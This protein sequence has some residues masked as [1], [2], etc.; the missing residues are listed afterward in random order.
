MKLRIISFA[1]I[2]AGA[3]QL[4][5]KAVAG[6]PELGAL[7]QFS[8]N[9]TGGGAVSGSIYDGAIHSGV[10]GI[11]NGTSS[12]SYVLQ[13][14]DPFGGDTADAYE[15]AQAP[16]HATIAG[17][18]IDT[19]YELGTAVIANQ[20][21]T[22]ITAIGGPDTSYVTFTDNTTKEFKG[23]ITLS[24]FAAG[25]IYGG[26]QLFSNT[27]TVDLTPGES[28]NIV[29]N[30]EASNYGG[31]NAVPAPDAGSTAALLGVALAALAGLRRRQVA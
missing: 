23:T 30:N 16:G 2:A 28:V 27:G 15:A 20:A 31:Y 1:I 14:G 25:G 21:G 9:L 18:A 13:G 29:L 6:P 11:A 3:I 17:F 8:G 19:H 24:G 5:P 10:F 4:T 12:D 26:P 22:V 7:F